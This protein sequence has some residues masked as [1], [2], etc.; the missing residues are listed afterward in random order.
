L[1]APINTLH[2]IECLVEIV[3]GDLN[4]VQW[5]MTD[6]HFPW[7]VM[8][9]QA[10]SMNGEYFLLSSRTVGNLHKSSREHRVVKCRSIL[11]F[12]NRQ[13]LSADQCRS[14]M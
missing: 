8:L 4:F 1:A 9:T 2:A 7:S 6:F 5:T 14:Q 11:M 12:A 3:P 10:L 13:V